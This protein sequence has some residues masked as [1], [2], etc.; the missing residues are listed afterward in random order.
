LSRI[1]VALLRPRSIHSGLKTGFF[2][3]DH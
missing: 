2:T 3:D 1:L